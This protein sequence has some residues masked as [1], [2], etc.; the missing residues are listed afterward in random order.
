[1][2]TPIGNSG[3]PAAFCPSLK[4]FSASIISMPACTESSASV[5]SRF[6]GAPKMAMIASP[7]Y[8]S[9]IPCRSMM[10]STMTLK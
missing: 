4:P 2:P 1:M 6:T 3:P 5:L 10:M 8:L 9:T 7:M